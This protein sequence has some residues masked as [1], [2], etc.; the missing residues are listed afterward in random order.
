[1]KTLLLLTSLSFLSAPAFA[2][3]GSPRVVWCSC[4]PD[5]SEPMVRLLRHVK[6]ENSE[7]IQSEEIGTF[8]VPHMWESCMYAQQQDMRCIL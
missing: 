6:E 3:E 8:Y 1:M 4:K 2:A 5:R 7:V